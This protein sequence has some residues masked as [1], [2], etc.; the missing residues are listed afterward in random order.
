[1]RFIVNK[2]LRQT[3]YFYRFWSVDSFDLPPGVSKREA[4]QAQS[5]SESLPV[6]DYIRFIWCGGIVNSKSVV[7]KSFHV[8]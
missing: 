7:L 8:C 1:M 5:D 6:T 2:S 3:V 4:L